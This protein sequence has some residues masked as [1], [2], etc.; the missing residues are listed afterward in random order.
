MTLALGAGA[1]MAL[2]LLLEL[3]A[4][5][6]QRAL[7]GLWAG[8]ERGRKPAPP[9]D[10]G[11]ELRAERR[12]RALLR[13][14]VSAEEWEMYR[15]LGFIRVW[16]AAAQQDTEG[17]PPA[18]EYAY[19]IYPHKPVVGYLVATGEVIG[20]YC[21]SFPREVDGMGARLPDADDVLAKWML[22]TGDER[23]L[24]EVANVHLPGRQIDPQRLQAD[25]LALERFDRLRAG[26]RAPAKRQAPA[27]T[28]T[29]PAK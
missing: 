8:E 18:A 20:E 13:S 16:G 11:R 14:C 24:L 7:R 26:A 15:E 1:L 23:A 9:Y 3:T 25:L 22:L 27:R 10:P 29:L 2:V 28:G 4:E 21:V 12:A 6:L 19:L 5:P 17:R